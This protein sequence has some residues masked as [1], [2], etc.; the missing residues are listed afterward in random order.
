MKIAVFDTETH[1]TPILKEW[2]YGL[3]DLNHNV[4]FYATQRYDILSCLNIKYDLIIYVGDLNV[5]KF[6]I[7][8]KSQPKT[9]IVCCV[10]DIK[11]HYKDLKGL[12]EFFVSIHN[13]N[14]ILKNYFDQIGFKFHFI[15]LAGNNH[16][17]YPLEIEKKYDICFIGTLSHGYRGED[18]Y[19]YPFIENKKYNFYLG[20]MIYKNYGIP[21]IPYEESN[22]I[23]NQSKININFHYDCQKPHKKDQPHRIDLNQSVFN[24]A[25]SGNFQICDHPL[26]KEIFG[27]SIIT[28]ENNWSELIEYYLH[29]D[30]ERKRLSNKAYHI[31]LQ[32]HTWK[33]RMGEFLNLLY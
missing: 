32:N 18:K 12:V 14:T 8:K 28:S 25:L 27:D 31:A 16:L 24:I 10:D 19:L 13:S 22:L 21:F 9:K 6:E 17:F 33:T 7:F 5:K 23:R 4:D 26:V 1:P 2:G 29:N 11:P 30:E 3:V 15:P 20:G